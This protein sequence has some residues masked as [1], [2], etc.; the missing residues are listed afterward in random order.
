VTV[1]LASPMSTT[2][3]L[4]AA[5]LDMRTMVGSL[6]VHTCGGVPAINICMVHRHSCAGM[7]S[8]DHIL[9]CSRKCKDRKQP[10]RQKA[11]MNI[12]SNTQPCKA[13]TPCLT[14]RYTHSG[15]GGQ[16][17]CYRIMN[18]SKAEMS[19]QTL[20]CLTCLISSDHCQCGASAYQC[21]PLPLLQGEL[22]L[23]EE[24]SAVAEQLTPPRPGSQ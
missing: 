21:L 20:S 13:H 2:L 9:P 3:P 8:G 14:A 4:G 10:Q 22:T 12:E 17:I 1:A 23:R 16:P 18:S 15:T 11:G 7:R 19:L 6:Q 24:P 5:K